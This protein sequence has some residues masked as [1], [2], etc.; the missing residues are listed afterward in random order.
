[1]MSG[2]LWSLLTEGSW[3]H[4]ERPAVVTTYW[5]ILGSWWAARCG[6]YL[7]RDPGLIMSGPLW[8]LQVDEAGEGGGGMS[9]LISLLLCG[10]VS[11]CCLTSLS[12]TTDNYSLNLRLFGLTVNNNRLLYSLNLSLFGLTVNNNRSLYSLNLI[13]SDLTVNNNR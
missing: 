11:G 3:A 4:D 5:G 12:I 13:L 2:P 6:H 9:V 8:S 10:F 1:M 7:L